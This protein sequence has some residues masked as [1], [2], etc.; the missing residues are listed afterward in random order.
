MALEYPHTFQDGVGQV[1]S[2]AEVMDNFNAVITAQQARSY[3]PSQNNFRLA[4]ERLCVGPEQILHVAQS[5]YHDV[6]PANQLGIASV[7]VNREDRPG[8]SGG[9]A[10]PAQP[11]LVVPD[12]ATLAAMAV[13]K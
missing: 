3:K 13:A 1:A 8:A 2:G 12:M 10:S 11:D 6:G 5:L 7:W 9:P 4:L